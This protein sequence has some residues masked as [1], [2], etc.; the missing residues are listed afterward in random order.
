V[1]KPYYDRFRGTELITNGVDLEPQASIQSTTATL[2]AYRVT[3]FKYI[4]FAA[5]RVIP[6][7][8]CHL[9][10][11]AFRNMEYNGQLLV[12]GHLDKTTEYGQ[13]LCQMADRRVCFIPFIS[14]QAEVL[15][16][17][18]QA[19]M[20][21]FPS[22]NKYGMEGMS[23]MILE[24]VSLGM[25]LLSSDIPQNKAVLG[26]YGYYFR[27]DDADD[28]AEKLRWAIEHPAKMQDIAKR[29][30]EHVHRNYSWDRVTQQYDAVYALCKKSRS[31]KLMTD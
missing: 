22:T 9:L 5:N 10:L 14:S 18:K 8:G 17:V 29:A 2:S 31:V 4:L 12:L 25:P 15:G 16:L 24:V 11:E 3:P 13:N 21:V 30:Q 20:F 7:K 23:M 26:D 6:F 27:S 28:L 19:N 1:I